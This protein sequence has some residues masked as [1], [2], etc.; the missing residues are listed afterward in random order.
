MT[1]TIQTER[2]TTQRM[3]PALDR[4]PVATADVMLDIDDLAG[5]PVDA[6][7][8]YANATSLDDIRHLIATT[9]RIAQ[10]HRERGMRAA[11][12]GGVLRQHLHECA[13]EGQ[14]PDAAPSR[15]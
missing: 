4:D 14:A 1:D 8:N 7:I 3:R 6:Q 10:E 12:L 5:M 9:E 13:N 11:D 15:G 2:G